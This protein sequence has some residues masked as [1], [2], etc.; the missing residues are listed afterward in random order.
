[1]ANSN[2]AQSPAT[3][4]ETVLVVEGDVLL[5]AM[6]SSHLKDCGL[7]VIQA[8]N[9]DEAKTV[10]QQPDSA[11]DV[12]LCE[13][14]IPD[15]INGFGLAQWIRAQRPGLPI[16]LVGTPAAADNAA[17][18]LCNSGPIPMNALQPEIILQRMRRLLASRDIP[19]EASR[20]M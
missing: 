8:A 13:V 6:I 4:P 5:R 2:L 3:T 16:M 14:S 9:A 10:L 11:A 19:K 17:A 12:V 1:M 18:E 15:S 20:R 7:R